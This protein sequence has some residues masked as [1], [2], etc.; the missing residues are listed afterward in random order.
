MASAPRP[1]RPQHDL[2]VR[3]TERLGPHL[4]RVVLGGESLAGFTDNG[5]TDSY[6]KLRLT[7]ADG[8]PVTRT[9]TV[10]AID[11]EARELTIDF[12]T[13]GDTGLAGPW[14]MNAKPGDP[15]TLTGPGGGYA[16][17][18]DGW[19]LFIADMAA[20]PAVAAALES[21][22]AHA[23][24]AAYL[25]AESSEDVLD[26]DAPEGVEINWIVEAT[27][28]PERLAKRAAERDWPADV[29]VFAHGEREAMKAVR[30]LL[31]ERD[32]PRES[33]SL[34]GY[35]ARGRTEEVFQAEKKQPIGKID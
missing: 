18:A 25:E 13:H 29:R 14:A 11:R 23:R 32:V 30:R 24:G 33:V 31:R 20:V 10:R 4:V 2:H 34:S 27:P 35:W 3:R 21:L 7:D 26:L 22:P 12:V 28:D 5:F 6:V 8:D 15:L 19:H 9:Y 1:P 17:A 16:P